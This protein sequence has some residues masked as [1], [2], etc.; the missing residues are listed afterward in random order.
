M[1]V[2]LDALFKL[3]QRRQEEEAAKPLE[4]R[5]REYREKHVARWETSEE[6]KL[7][8]EFYRA[9][10]AYKEHLRAHPRD[11]REG[12]D[13]PLEFEE[14]QVFQEMARAMAEY[15]KQ[16]EETDKR[17]LEKAKLAARCTHRRAG[18]Q[19]CGSPR[20]KGSKYC[21]GHERLMAA[22]TQDLELPPLED[23]NSI[24]LSLTK[25][26]HA[27]MKGQMDLKS[28]GMFF[29]GMQIVASVMGRVKFGEAEER[30]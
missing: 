24:V 29:Y 15:Q 1:G 22:R 4:Q 8:L 13:T 30:S 23:A 6:G 27:M 21:Y 14:H 28:A 26:L 18:G 17:N 2:S 12:N 16:R 5:R 7:C 3:A 9:Y 25:A 20:M 10:T 11:W 19:Y